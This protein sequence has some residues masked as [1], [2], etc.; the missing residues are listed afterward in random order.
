LI[1]AGALLGVTG[2]ILGAYGAHGLSASE[3]QAD[4]WAVA[5]Q[6]QLIHSLLMLI[7][8]LWHHFFPV[9][10]L[11]ISGLAFVAGI[12]LFSGSIYLLVL[13]GP[14]LLGPVTPMGGVVLI[15]GWLCLGVAGYQCRE[16]STTA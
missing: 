8:A 3:S 9:K 11:L 14:S 12:F 13:G 5:V 10:A 6:Y 16:D 1:F 15:F 2:V 7:V 4:S